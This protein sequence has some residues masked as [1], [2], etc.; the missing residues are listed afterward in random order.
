[1]ASAV[2]IK[3]NGV[4]MTSS[5]LPT[6][7][8]RRARCKASVPEATPTACPTPWYD[9]T[10]CSS[11]LPWGPRMN[12]VLLMTPRTA[13]SISS[14]I[15]SYWT[16]K[17]T[18]GTDML[19]STPLSLWYGDKS[20]HAAFDAFGDQPRERKCGL[21]LNAGDQ[22]PGPLL[23]ALKKRL[24]LLVQGVTPLGRELAR[25]ELGHGAVS[26]PGEKCLLG[27]VI[28]EIESVAVEHLQD[29]LLLVRHPAGRDVGHAAVLEQ[30]ASHDR[31]DL[32]G[33]DG[34]SHGAYLPGYRPREVAYDI[35]VVDHE[36]EHYVDVR[37]PYGER[38]TP[39][40]LQVARRFEESLDRRDRR[41]EPFY[42]AYLEDQRL[43]RRQLDKF[44][45]LFEGHRDRFFE[46][47]MDALLKELLCHAVMERGRHD[48]A[49]R[50]D[51]AEK[52]LRPRKRQGASF[53]GDLGRPRGVRVHHADEFGFRM[54]CVFFGVEL[55][56]VAD[57]DDAHAQFLHHRA[58]PSS[59][60][61]A[62]L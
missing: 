16:F 26:S 8:A 33:D 51:P 47:D 49:H 54:V 41:V 5:P 12:A 59:P 60:I 3:V 17:S 11:A 15:A 34:R 52:V 61:P 25:H 42:M 1:M 10:P 23:H 55:A 6:P 35:E 7:A 57:A 32:P 36:V 22:G 31:I 19:F 4:V 24:D 48:N 30:D 2:A 39:L 45:G 62:L 20:G 14:L 58:I 21:S 27:L 28:R 37:A 38:R 46:Q 9:A 50:V 44:I 56:Q 40:S 43:S 13:L 18:M 29:A 53:P